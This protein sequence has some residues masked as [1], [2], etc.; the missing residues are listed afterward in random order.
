MPIAAEYLHDNRI[1]VVTF[2]T[3]LDLREYFIFVRKEHAAVYDHATKS[4]HAILD[5]SAVKGLPRGVLSQAMNLRQLRHRMDGTII[6]VVSDPVN[7]HFLEIFL[8]L[9]RQ[10]NFLHTKTKEEAMAKIEEILGKETDAP[11]PRSAANH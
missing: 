3:E 7:T 6:V 10:P 1:C 5:L 2:P 8:Q 11:I 4:I 9:L